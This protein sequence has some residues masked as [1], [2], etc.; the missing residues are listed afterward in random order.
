MSVRA[1]NRATFP[2]Q[3][4]KSGRVLLLVTLVLTPALMWAQGGPPFRTDDPATPGNR[5]WEI[6]VGLTTDRRAEER[7]FEAPI[8]DINFGAG[9]RVQ[10]KFE[11][12]WL[13][14]GTDDAPTKSGL[15]NSRFGVKW[16]FHEDKKR[17]LTISMYPQV[18]FNNPN[19]S[20]D[21]G[22][23]ERGARV[24]LPIE[25][26]KKVG[27]VDVNGEIGY[28]ITQHG[29]NQWIAG[30]AVGKQA[31]KK[32]ELVGELYATGRI[33]GQDRETTFDG[34]GRY[35]IRSPVV[36]LF[37]V[38]RSFRGP[39]SGEPQLFG[40]LGVQFLIS[41]KKQAHAAKKGE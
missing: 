29:S 34:G 16:R 7:E 24:L 40:Y 32:L 10:L 37:M 17:D 9:E 28:W 39:A 13:I 35:K 21:R 5:N 2:A 20:A 30:L 25:V 8:L 31:T 6:N 11:V 27:P 15:G 33:N 36:L 38:G 12:P 23:V 26:A 4:V 18:D 3:S 19:N 41:S 1:A 14:R 22:L